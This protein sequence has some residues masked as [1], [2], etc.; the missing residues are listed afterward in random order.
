MQHK[1]CTKQPYNSK[2]TL[3]GSVAKSK[4]E[5]TKVTNDDFMDKDEE[6]KMLDELHIPDAVPGQHFA[7]DWGFMQGK[8][9]SKKTEEGQ[10]I[11]SIDGKRCYCLIVDRAT[12][13]MWVIV[14][15]SKEPPVN[16]VR[17]F[18]KKFRSKAPQRLVQLDQDKALGKSKEF[19][20]YCWRKM[21]IL[22]HNLLA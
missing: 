8:N 7:M 17:D 18:L 19:L 2:T 3:L 9:Y 13:C 14:S 20:K 22:Y 5:A 11:T 16:A 1:L 10:L 4:G 21:S 15:D 12:R 6:E